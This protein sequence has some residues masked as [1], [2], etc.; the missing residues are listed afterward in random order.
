MC[1]YTRDSALDVFENNYL[2]LILGM[3]TGKQVESYGV[4][5]TVSTP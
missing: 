3:Q 5:S 4:E 2:A 1:R